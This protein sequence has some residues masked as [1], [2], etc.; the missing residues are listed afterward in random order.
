ML[1]NVLWGPG[2]YPKSLPCSET[3]RKLCSIES[4]QHAWGEDVC[5]R[6]QVLCSPAMT[7]SSDPIAACRHMSGE[8]R[9]MAHRKMPPVH[10]LSQPYIWPTPTGRDFNSCNRKYKTVATQAT[11]K[12]TK[13]AAILYDV[14]F[15]I[16]IFYPSRSVHHYINKGKKSLICSLALSFDRCMPGMALPNLMCSL[17]FPLPRGCQ[18]GLTSPA[19]ND[20]LYLP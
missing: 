14:I 16:S 3:R 17:T 4:L 1:Y 2:K 15:R 19:S 13:D 10:G 6:L 20:L 9:R 7:P 8:E 11:D 12:K 5:V 18:C